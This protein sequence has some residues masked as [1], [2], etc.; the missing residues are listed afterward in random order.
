MTDK[1][2]EAFEKWARTE[3]F[4]LTSIGG[5]Y[6]DNE[7]HVAWG[8]WQAAQS[9]LVAEKLECCGNPVEGNEYMGQVQLVCC[10]NPEPAGIAASVP[11]VGEKS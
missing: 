4:D 8:A 6:S 1:M 2:R 11:V 7:T 9:V 3:C 5:F 10:G